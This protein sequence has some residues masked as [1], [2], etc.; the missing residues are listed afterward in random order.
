VRSKNGSKDQKKKDISINA[1]YLS[2]NDL[3]EIVSK[4]PK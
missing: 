3:G 1:N 4:K 2:Q